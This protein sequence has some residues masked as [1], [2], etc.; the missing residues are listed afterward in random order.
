MAAQ[1][2][3]VSATPPSFIS[4]ANLL[5]VLYLFIQVLDEDVEQI[6]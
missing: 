2:S 4:S 6:S 3:G 1:P 5:R